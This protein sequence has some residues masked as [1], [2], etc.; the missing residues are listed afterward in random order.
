MKPSPAT[1]PATTVPCVPGGT[2]PRRDASTRGRART[3]SQSVARTRSLSANFWPGGRGRRHADLDAGK[4]GG[5]MCDAVYA[6]DTGAG[7][8]ARSGAVFSTLEGVALRRPGHGGK[9]GNG[10]GEC[11]DARRTGGAPRAILDGE[12]TGLGVLGECKLLGA[13]CRCRA[14]T[15]APAAFVGRL[16]VGIVFRGSGNSERKRGNADRGRK[17]HRAPRQ[18]QAVRLN[19]LVGKRLDDIR[20]PLVTRNAVGVGPLNDLGA[21][22]AVAVLEVGRAR[23]R[24]RLKNVP[25]YDAGNDKPYHDQMAPEKTAAHNT[26]MPTSDF[27]KQ[28]HLS[29]LAA[30]AKAARRI[31]DRVAA[32]KIQAAHR[33]AGLSA[34]LA[35]ATALGPEIIHEGKCDS[36][37][38]VAVAELHRQRHATRAPAVHDRAVG[39]ADAELLKHWT[40]ERERAGD[41]LSGI[42]ERE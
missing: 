19:G 17:T 40:K 36:D 24:C 8:R 38:A 18:G 2:V 29:H 10:Q 9:I 25:Q 37:A 27:R 6:D 15:Q 39:S 35:T 23:L 13:A 22:G 14:R 31:P 11:S 1:G 32:A 34:G 3:F 5:R 7:D 28:I 42:A 12:G 16:A 20:R 21:C 30:A 41:E 4:V 26:S 33:A